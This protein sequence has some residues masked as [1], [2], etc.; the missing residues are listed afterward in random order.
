MEYTTGQ[1][2][3]DF[4]LFRREVDVLILEDLLK[5]YR[6]R[7]SDGAALSLVLLLFFSNALISILMQL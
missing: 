3:G 4:S 2:E 7:R 5:I 1:G 6:N